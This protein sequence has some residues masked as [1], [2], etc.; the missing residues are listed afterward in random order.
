MS[1]RVRIE[2][3]F[4]CSENAFWET[5]LNT[6]YNKE[7]F[8]QRMK[9][10]RWELL[11]FELSDEEMQRLVEV[12][13]YVAELPGPIKKV[14]GDNIRYKEEGKLD[15]KAGS[16][17]FRI[18]P[19]KLAEKILISGKQFTQSLGEHRCRRVFEAE[20]EIKVFGI[21]SMIEKNIVSDLRKSYDVGAAFTQD[22][23]RRHGI[24]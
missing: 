4:E 9:F 17:S 18:L 23:M 12:E 20:V 10:P 6:E 14:I 3:D 19:S 24:S 13:P 15:R 8:C 21:G 7:M 5:F 2:H 11:K 16:Y 1:E 22:Y